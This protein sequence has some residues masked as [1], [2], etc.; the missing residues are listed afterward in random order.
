MRKE[1]G[2]HLGEG[3]QWNDQYDANHP[4]ARNNGQGDEHHEDVFEKSHG[5]SLGTGV[6]SIE[7]NVD[8]GREETS[9]KSNKN[10]W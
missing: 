8:D 2:G 5:Y 6:F 4:Q 10:Q 1:V 7:G 3:E 9:E